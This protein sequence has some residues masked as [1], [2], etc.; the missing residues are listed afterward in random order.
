MLVLRTIHLDK[1]PSTPVGGAT[2]WTW[3]IY[4]MDLKQLILFMR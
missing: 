1:A 4:L 3:K 2:M